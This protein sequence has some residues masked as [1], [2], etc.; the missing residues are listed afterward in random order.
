MS[1]W[2]KIPL[3]F[4]VLLIV[5]AALAWTVHYVNQPLLASHFIRH[6]H[7]VEALNR[8]AMRCG[9]TVT[10]EVP[11]TENRARES[12]TKSYAYLVEVQ[13]TR[14][15]EF[16]DT[17][18]KELLWDLALKA[19][20]IAGYSRSF[21]PDEGSFRFRYRWGRRTSGVAECNGVQESNGTIR[22]KLTLS[23]TKK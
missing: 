16:L 20:T 13:N 1:K 12:L 21:S 23:E 17:F 14:C 5:V 18:Q 3:S 11:V 6:G 7:P 15:M 10:N 2:L 22:I 9:G 8:A 4:V 19:G